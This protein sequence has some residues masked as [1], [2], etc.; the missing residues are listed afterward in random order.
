MFFSRLQIIK[1]KKSACKHHIKAPQHPTIARRLNST[2]CSNYSYV[3][4]KKG[5]TA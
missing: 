1:K 2:V 4:Y 5:G 3:Q